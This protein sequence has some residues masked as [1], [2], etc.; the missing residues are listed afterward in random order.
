LESILSAYDLLF[1]EM[2]EKDLR[3]WINHN[4]QGKLKGKNG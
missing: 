4:K 2:F 3:N 1:K